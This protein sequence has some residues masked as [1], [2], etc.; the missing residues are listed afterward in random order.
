MISV[1]VSWFER[2]PRRIDWAM[3]FVL[4][5]LWAVY[6]WRLWS[7]NP[8][9]RVS[10]PEGDYSGQFLAFGAYQAERLLA[11]EIPLWNPYNNAGHPFLADTQAAVFYP[12][13]ILTIFISE[14][15]FEGW[16]YVALQTETIIHYLLASIFMYLLVRTMTKSYSGGLAGAIVFSYSGFLTGYPPLQLAVLET[17]AWTPLIVLGI[18]L[19]S[20]SDH[21]NMRW[22]AFAGM[23]L[24]ISLLAGHPQ[25]SLFTSYLLVALIIHRAVKRS[26]GWRTT[27]GALVIVVGLGYGLAL[28][29]LLPGFEYTRLTTRAGFGF[30]QLAGGFPYSDLLTIIYPESLTVWSPLYQGVLSLILAGIAVWSAHRAARFWGTVAL[31][32]LTLAFGGAALTY[33]LAYQLVPGF[34]LFR[35]QE[36]AAFVI[37]FSVAILCGYGLVYITEKGAAI[38]LDQR[39]WYVVGGAWFLAIQVFMLSTV[40]PQFDLFALIKAAF[41]FA[42]LVTF[43]MLLLS[44]R[45]NLGRLW[46]AAACALIVFDLFSVTINTN[47]EPIAARE[48]EII[49][50]AVPS[51]PVDTGLFRVDGRVGLGENYGTL[52]GLQDIRGTSPLR[53]A[54]SAQYLDVLSQQRLYQL[55]GIAYSFT[56][57]QQ[58]EM[59]S[60]IVFEQLETTPPTRLHQIETPLP[61]AWV[62]A[63]IFEVSN[64]AE[65]LG[66]IND[67]SFDP[68]TGVTL[69]EVPP[70]YQASDADSSRATVDVMIYEPEFIELRVESSSGGILVLSEW[71]YPGW[72]ATID[73]SPIEIYRANA[74]LRSVVVEE[75]TQQVVFE[76][77]PTSFRVGAVFSIVCLLVSFVLVVGGWPIGGKVTDG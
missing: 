35:G 70:G 45:P 39:S 43:S 2:K 65:A 21:W 71:D 14:W 13:R 26:L 11:G 29:Q 6:F 42:L 63:N 62:A 20:D 46:S 58:L 18:Y 7:P 41:L 4:V 67:P 55:L 25:T 52:V 17:A 50:D 77:R 59:P 10:F 30:D 19:A 68:L 49:G 73:G 44:Q 51:V 15:L 47:F 8:A 34:G 74:G 38:N 61:R 5:L 76:Y 24:G 36:R 66:L 72:R 69:E 37:A 1:V 3:M 33:H 60:T 27:L 9:N 31:V 54:S 23:A 75:G 53:L 22:L 32:A 57:A 28:I 16:N 64:D 48:R 56:D 12:P 40:L